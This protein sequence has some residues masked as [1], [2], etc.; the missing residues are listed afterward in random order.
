MLLGQPSSSSFFLHLCVMINFRC[1]N[2]LSIYLSSASATIVWYD[3]IISGLY[4][5]IMCL[6]LGAEPYINRRLYIYI[7]VYV[8]KYIYRRLFQFACSCCQATIKLSQCEYVTLL[9]QSRF[10][11]K[12]ACMSY[13][14]MPAHTH[15]HTHT[16]THEHTHTYTHNTITHTAE[17]AVPYTH[18]NV[19]LCYVHKAAGQMN[20]FSTQSVYL[21]SAAAVSPSVKTG[22]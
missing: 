18:V 16:H 11:Q 13:A 8:Y 9:W 7:Y 14:C 17:Q 19:C 4:K 15:T 1:T 12:L 22:P 20:V 2:V 5:F 3:S 6:V 10:T 21:L